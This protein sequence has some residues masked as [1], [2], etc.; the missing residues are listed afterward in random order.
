MKQK[1][2]YI[3]IILLL[4]GCASR[5]AIQSSKHNILRIKGSDSMSLLTQRCAEEFM[6]T[7][8]EASVYAEGGGSRIGID[9]LING[10]IDICASS[11]PLQ[12]SEVQQLA[13]RYHSLGMA[14]ICA[15]D[16]LGIVVHR[17]NPINNLTVEEI[18]K[19]FTGKISNWNELGGKIMPITTYCREPNS[20]T[21]LF[22]QEHLLFDEPYS[23]DCNSSGGARAL[24]DAVEKDSTAISYSTFV[25]S[26]SVKLLSVNGVP[27]TIKN[28]R[29]GA[30]LISRYLY[31]YTIQPPD[32]LIKNFIDWVV[33]PEGQRVI[34][35]C[36]YIP[37]YEM[38]K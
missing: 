8:P 5:D 18:K 24:I 32:G 25:Y 3:I 38:G 15:K 37:L 28:V 19:I 1:N 9:A 34:Q 17:S 33:S 7:H 27:P 20:G 13:E 36:G 31:L 30:Y 26:R 35:E 10:T 23:A 21:Y 14:T 11:R 4:H 12:P 29:N 2:F 6:K 16:A 22:F